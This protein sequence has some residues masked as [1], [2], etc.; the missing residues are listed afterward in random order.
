[1]KPHLSIIG[2]ALIATASCT[3][4]PPVAP[5]E[6]ERVPTGWRQV[7][8]KAFSFYAPP[9]I[10]EVALDGIAIDSYVMEFRAPSIALH[11]DYGRYS[12]SLQCS[13]DQTCRSHAESVGGR[14]ARFASWSQDQASDKKSSSQVGVYFPDTGK[15]GMRLMMSAACDDYV[16]CR[17]AEEIFRTIRFAK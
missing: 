15:E 9:G 16:S 8:V 13:G 6:P 17:D 1:M 10:H 12:N 7:D 11:F 5:A 4:P 14:Q 3:K 2:L